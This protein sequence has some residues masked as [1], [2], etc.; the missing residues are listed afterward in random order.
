[1]QNIVLQDSPLVFNV[2]I[3]FYYQRKLW[4]GWMNIN[5][6][7]GIMVLG[8]PGY[9][10]G[11]A[12][13]PIIVGLFASKSTGYG[14][15]GVIYGTLAAAA[16]WIAAAGLRERPKVAASRTESQPLRALLD[17]LQNRPFVRLLAAYL[18]ANTGFALVKTLL[19]YYLTYQLGMKDQVP[20]VMFLLLAFVALFLFPWKMVSDR[21]N[22]GPAYA[23]GLAIG[24]LAVAATFILPHQ[25]TAWVYVI[26]V[27][28]GI[29]FSANWVFPWA[30]VPDVVE[31]DRLKT[32]EYRD[33]IYYGV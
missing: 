20:V 5:P 2:P 16:L 14:M 18:T 6:F 4:D 1:M 8:V 9:M 12:V 27:V 26:A 25:P 23:L 33:G 31:Y 17:T 3:Q 24:G 28:A 32:D 19:A 7:R 29:G 30:M 22:K 11:A 15:V 13:T 10:I 21:W